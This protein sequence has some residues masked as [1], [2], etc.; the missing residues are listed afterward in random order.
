MAGIWL[1]KV[2]G[3]YNR[4]EREHVCS[5]ETELETMALIS[6]FDFRWDLDVGPVDK[7]ADAPDGKSAG[8]GG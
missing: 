3:E 5:H 7:I 2:G 1:V 8:D 4:Y 6:T